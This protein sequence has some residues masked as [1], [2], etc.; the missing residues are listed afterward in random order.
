MMFSYPKR[1][2]DDQGFV[3]SIDGTDNTIIREVKALDERIEDLSKK[4]DAGGS[5]QYDPE[6][7]NALSARV[8]VLEDETTQLFVTIGADEGE[9]DTNLDDIMSKLASHSSSIKELRLEDSALNGRINVL[10]REFDNLTGMIDDLDLR[11]S[12]N[13]GCIGK[14]EEAI[15]LIK[16]D[17]SHIK[18][19]I[20]VLEQESTAVDARLTA[21][22]AK[23]AE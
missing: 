3:K 22:E 6:V 7:I 17:I 10:R 16:S 21:L 1:Y 8:E 14:I 2:I 20:V 23:H 19:R 15:E 12:N 11:I 5:G 13:S 4:I 9:N 18:T